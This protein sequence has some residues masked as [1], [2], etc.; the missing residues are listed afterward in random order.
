MDIPI[1]AYAGVILFV[2]LTT[3]I[4][5]S[6]GSPKSSGIGVSAA[7]WVL[8]VSFITLGTVLRYYFGD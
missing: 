7:F 6:V 8:T 3:F 2:M 4:G 5:W 1:K